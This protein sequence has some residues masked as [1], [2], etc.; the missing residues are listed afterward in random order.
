VSGDG[1][2]ARYAISQGQ[3][4]PSSLPVRGRWNP[5]LAADWGTHSLAA[6]A[7]YTFGARIHHA[8]ALRTTPIITAT[9]N[10]QPYTLQVRTDTADGGPLAGAHLAWIIDGQ[11]REIS[12]TMTADSSGHAALTWTADGQQYDRVIVWI[13]S[14]GDATWD[15][16]VETT[17]QSIINW[18]DSSGNWVGGVDTPGSGTNGSDVT[19]TGGQVTGVANGAGAEPLPAGTQPVPEA[20]ASI[21]VLRLAIKRI[22][23]RTIRVLG[24]AS[25][26]TTKRVAFA[27]RT[28]KGRLL[29]RASAPLKA[30][31]FALRMKLKKPIRAARYRLAI[32]YEGDQRLKPLTLTRLVPLR[33]PRRTSA[34]AR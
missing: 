34:P 11:D 1:A 12:G 33:T 3:P 27:L 5:L 8:S 29:G 23:P 2:D 32:T 26:T 4:L 13:D 30:G 9:A 17:R 16:D 15:R 18:V 10:D 20:R 14:D 22:G 25:M 19:A 7:S 21:R 6:G 24:R 31:R 28:R